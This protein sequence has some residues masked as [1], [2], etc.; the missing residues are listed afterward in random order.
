MSELETMVVKYKINILLFY[1]ECIAADKNR[2][3]ELC[4][5]IT[6][7]RKK[8]P[9]EIK[10]YPQLT[11]HNID[12]ETLKMMKDAG[13]AGVSYGFESFSPTVLKSMNKPITPQMIESAFNKT[14]KAGLTMQVNF[15]FGDTA[16]TMETAMETLN[17]WKKNAQGQIHL[18]FI[19]PY[20][21]SKIYEYALKKGIIKDKEEFISSVVPFSKFNLTEKMTDKEMEVLRREILKATAKYSQFVVPKL[22]KVKDKIYDLDVKCPYCHSKFTYGNCYI[23]NKYV[24]GH[25]LPCRKCGMLFYIVS[26]IEKIGYKNY[27]FFRS[28]RDM[29]KRVQRKIEELKLKIRK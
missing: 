28:L 5:R 17:W 15:I 18:L 24:F 25:I 3:T 6:E 1:D 10:W 14:L 27:T 8:I 16:E 26:R 9:W 4:Q 22:T 29:Q 12:D 23:E 21:G 7:F 13:V 11:V 2:L 19:Q 20:A